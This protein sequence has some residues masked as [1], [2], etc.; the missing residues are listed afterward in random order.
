MRI[1]IFLQCSKT[2]SFAIPLNLKWTESSTIEDWNKNW[3]NSENKYLVRD[4]YNGRSIKKEFDL[5]GLSKHANVYV[6]SA[7]AGLVPLDAQIPS[8]EASFN[9]NGP[10][11]EKWFRLPYG[12]L[13]KI[14]PASEDVIVSFAS[15]SYHRALLKDPFIKNIASNLIV[16]HTSPLSKLEGV[17]SVV[18]HPRTAELLGVAS[19]DLNTEL[20]RI[21][22]ENGIEGFS[23]IYSKCELLPPVKNRTKI[24]DTDLELLVKQLGEIKTIKD[25]VHHIRHNLGI[26][27]SYDRI[28]RQ[29]KK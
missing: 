14:Q 15:P 21:Y 26:S 1:Y 6:I 11:V 28:R 3:E 20:L 4:L 29:I 22:L 9:A 13:Q 5:I 7:G 2:K 19:I 27:A 24:S 23:E 25:T 12:G 17:C 16:A 10:D 18:I 8:Y